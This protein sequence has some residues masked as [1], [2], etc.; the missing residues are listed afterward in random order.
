MEIPLNDEPWVV[1]FFKNIWQECDGSEAAISTLINSVLKWEKAWG[2]DLSAVPGL[3][4]LLVDY[5]TKIE[6]EGMRKTV[7]SM[8]F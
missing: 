1:G 5:L 7:R 8:L 4:D 3:H 2:M 6:K